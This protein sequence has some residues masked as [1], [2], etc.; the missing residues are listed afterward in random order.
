M[1]QYRFGATCQ[2]LPM[3]VGDAGMRDVPPVDVPPVDA[4]IDASVDVPRDA[5]T[6]DAPTDPGSTVVD[7]G[8]SVDVLMCS[9]A[10]IPCEGGGSATATDPTNCG[11]CGNV[12]E[13][14]PH[15]AADCSDCRCINPCDGSWRRLL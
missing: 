2:M 14:R 7:A 9:D 6:A 4:G 12:C 10:S 5:A 3:P 13:T 1:M 8:A 11:A 15:T